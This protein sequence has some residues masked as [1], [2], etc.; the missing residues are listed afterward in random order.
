MEADLGE[1][2][3]P[4]EVHEAD[5]GQVQD[6]GVEGHRGPGVQ[7]E[8][9]GAV[10]ARGLPLLLLL[11]PAAVEVSVAGGGGSGGGGGE[12]IVPGVEVALQLQLRDGLER[13]NGRLVNEVNGRLVNEVN[14]RRSRTLSSGVLT[15]SGGI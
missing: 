15:T 14:A 1:N 8:D 9:R 4:V 13:E 6:E 2:L 5:S 7:R 3:D 11:Q 12:R 10:G